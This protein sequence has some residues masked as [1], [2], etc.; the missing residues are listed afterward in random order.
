MVKG[1]EIVTDTVCYCLLDN[2]YF[3]RYF[4]LAENHWKIFGS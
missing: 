4:V 2:G 3:L 1:L